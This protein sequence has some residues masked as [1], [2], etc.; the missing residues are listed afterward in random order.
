[1]DLTE[2]REGSQVVIEGV[3]TE[4]V[5]RDRDP[6][7]GDAALDALHQRRLRY[8]RHREQLRSTRKQPAFADLCL[9]FR[10]I[11]CAL[12]VDSDRLLVV[13]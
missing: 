8:P 2:L 1:M 12:C 6:E 13:T 9:L 11:A 10:Q 3:L 7:H 4:V 5:A